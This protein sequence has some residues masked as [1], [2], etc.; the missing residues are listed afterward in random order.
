MQVGVIVDPT[1]KGI[2]C[3][4]TSDVLRPRRARST[5]RNIAWVA[6][7]MHAAQAHYGT[8]GPALN[9]RL[10]ALVPI[11]FKAIDKAELRR[12]LRGKLASIL[13]SQTMCRQVALSNLHFAVGIHA[14]G[15][16]EVVGR[17]HDPTASRSG[18]ANV[19]LKRG[20]AV[21]KRSMGVAIDQRASRH[22]GSFA[23]SESAPL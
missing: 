7:P 4:R 19:V 13:K 22:G 17:D 3:I 10:A 8:R 14:G 21:R 16:G 12:N 9:Q 11:A 15:Q 5:C 23:S 2:G 6:N 1:A 18:G 20:M